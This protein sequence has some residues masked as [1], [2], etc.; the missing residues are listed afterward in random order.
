MTAA[1]R[2]LCRLLCLELPAVLLLLDTVMIELVWGGEWGGGRVGGRP[3]V[4][5]RCF[6]MSVGFLRQG[7]S[8]DLEQ[9]MGFVG[10]LVSTPSCWGHRHMLQCP[11]F[12]TVV[13]AWN[14]GPHVWRAST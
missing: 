4:Y 8:L 13:R 11:D 7:L 14:I 10:P 6:K 1:L 9:T 3:E 5:T 12:Y 2:R